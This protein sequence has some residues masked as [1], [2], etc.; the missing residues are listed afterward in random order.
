MA[1]VIT[2]FKLETTQYDSKLRDAT[3]GLAQLAKDTQKAGGDMNKMS[4]E[5]VEA[6][7]SLGKLAGGA[8]NAKEKVREL[9]NAYNKL[10]KEY[11]DLSEKNKRSDF[12]KAMSDSMNELKGRIREAKQELYSSSNGAFGKYGQV[13]D[14]IGSKLGIAGNLTSMLTSKT[15]LLTAGIGA[16]TTV[17]AAGAKA[18]ADYNEQLSRRDNATMVTT[19]LKGNDADRMTDAMTSVAKVYNVDFREAINAAN[20]LMTQFG[21]SGDEAIQLIRDGM[22]G[23][24]EGDGPKLLS[25][26][27]QYAPSFRDAGI[28]ASQLV[29]IIHNSEGGIFTDQNMNAIVMGIKNIRLMTNSTSEALA[30]L[31]IDGE[32]MTHKL[33]DGSMT[34]FEALGKVSQAIEKTG[35]G[36]QAAGEVMQQVFGRQGAAAGTKLGEAIATLN[37]N[38]EETKNQ[39][40]E[41]GK[42][43]A[44]LE[45]A[46]DKL[47]SAI[48]DCFGWDGWKEMST[49]LKT[50]F[51]EG[52]TTIL[53]LV[54]KIKKTWGSIQWT[55]GQY[56]PQGDGSDEISWPDESETTTPYNPSSSIVA[57]SKRKI[58]E[59][60]RKL[61][62]SR[63]S[64]GG[65]RGGRG[66]GGHTGGGT[67]TIVVKT[68]EQL[69][70]EKIQEL[71]RS[72]EKASEERRA[73]I[74]E[75][76]K[77]LQERNKEIQRYYDIATGKVLSPTGDGKVSQLV[78]GPANFASQGFMQIGA[79]N[80]TPTLGQLQTKLAGVRQD[81]LLS[82]SSEEY[83]QYEVFAKALEE[84]IKKITGNDS[85]KK[86]VKLTD[87]LGNVA[88]GLSSVVGGME[89]LGIEVPEGMKDMIS[90]LQSIIGIVNGITTILTAIKAIQ[91]AQTFLHFRR[92]GIVPHAAGGYRVPGN[93]Y[94]D[95]TPIMVSSGEIIMNKAQQGN[96]LSQMRQARDSDHGEIV[97]R[98][99]GEDILLVA[100]RHLRRT[101]KGELVTWKS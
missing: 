48:R 51:V 96:L 92:G 40:G 38:L 27:Q 67:D 64:G 37:T 76:I 59:A 78:A 70:N 85:D 24:I 17:V 2:R 55:V 95:M 53:R 58:A 7:R 11:N 82:T 88:S 81:Q 100:N 22:Q 79:L 45:L 12:A 34:I 26:I 61:R 84:S 50:D 32:E 91:T 19:G 87:Q 42:A 69:N 60:K 101:G 54:T 89:Q 86:E 10:A 15:A 52:L 36:S 75:E 49:G 72:Y 63:S 31:G 99:S 66:G 23:M 35:S 93:D 71:A 25:M 62:S 4:K 46:T 8:T 30:K 80:T 14:T 33:N 94:A 20:T 41:V 18:W 1:D 44:E 39:T 77:T 3:K 13:V 98:L 28:S 97:A 56:Y 6:A 47:N 90:G 65:G 29:A 73:A 5:Q 43:T 68:E 21:L 16:A 9:V 74:R 57:E 83:S